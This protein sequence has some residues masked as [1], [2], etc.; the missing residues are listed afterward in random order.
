MSRLQ[1]D[2]I[3]VEILSFWRWFFVGNSVFLLKTG[4]F[5]ENKKNM[6]KG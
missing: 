2:K 4:D 1:K 5:R 3:S 6:V